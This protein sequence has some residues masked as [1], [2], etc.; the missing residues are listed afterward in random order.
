[1][2]PVSVATA[3]MEPAYFPLPICGQRDPF[4]CGTRRFWITHAVPS[5]S[6]PKPPVRSMLLGGTKGRGRRLI[7]YKSAKAFI[8][9]IQAAQEVAP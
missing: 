9:R 4:F 5:K 7:D 8:A 3:V 6:R 1:M 2:K